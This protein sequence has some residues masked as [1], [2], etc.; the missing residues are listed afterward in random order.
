[1]YLANKLVDKDV[2]IR[3]IKLILRSLHK[4]RQ[5][6]FY[7]FQKKLWKLLRSRKQSGD[8]YTRINT[9]DDEVWIE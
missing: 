3:A 8:E 6:D 7:E 4:N 2:R 5:H 1:M 9:I